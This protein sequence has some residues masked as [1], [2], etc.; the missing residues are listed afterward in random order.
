[1]E[2]TTKKW[3]TGCG[4]GCILII[5]MACLV[6]FGGYLGVKKMIDAARETSAAVETVTARFGRV[7]DFTPDPY[8]NVEPERLETF[9]LVREL[10]STERARLEDSLA[11]LSGTEPDGGPTSV[12]SMARSLRAG[13]GFMPQM[14]AYINARNSAFLEAEMGLG[15]Y[16][17]LYTIV[18]ESWLGK[19]PDDGPPFVLVGGDMDSNGWSA[20]EVRSQRGAEIRARLNRTTLPMLRNQLAALTTTDA[21]ADAQWTESLRTE[22]LLMESDS[23]RL[24]W[25]DGLPPQTA[26]DLEPFFE[27]LDASYS[28]LCH[29]VE[30]AVMQH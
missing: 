5:A 14:M 22:I 19:A 8:G 4:I 11:Q 21:T 27:D 26:T 15:E 12:G 23:L 30:F 29:P 9:L 1:M 13:F 16:L 20:T 2:E 3:L 6:I 18:Y 17:H 10:C 25:Q 28:A 7:S 24:P